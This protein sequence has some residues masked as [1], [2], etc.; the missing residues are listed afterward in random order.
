MRNWYRRYDMEVSSTF[1][2]MIDFVCT[3]GNTPRGF[4]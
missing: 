1:N 2:C 4:L 3:P